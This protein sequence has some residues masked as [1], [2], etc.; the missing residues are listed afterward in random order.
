MIM[1]DFLTLS[2]L[3]LQGK[4]VLVRADLNV[5]M[6]DGRVSDTERLER[7]LPTLKDLSKA[8]AKIVL[9]S[10]FGRPKGIDPKC[11]PK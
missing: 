4:T 11:S 3:S 7:L 9:L 2:D 6:Q 10:H 5:P 8:S 1:V